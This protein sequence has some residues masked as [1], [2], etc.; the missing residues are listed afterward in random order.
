MILEYCRSNVASLL[1]TEIKFSTAPMFRESLD[2]VLFHVTFAIRIPGHSTLDSLRTEGTH[3]GS[4]FSRN[5]A[6]NRDHQQLHLCHG[7]EGY[8]LKLYF[9]K[10]AREAKKL[11]REAKQE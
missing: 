10:L 9:R 5:A 3:L 11:A 7:S 1:P 2:T 8:F 6:N 4:I